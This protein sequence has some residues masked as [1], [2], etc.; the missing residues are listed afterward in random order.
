MEVDVVEFLNRFSADDLAEKGVLRGTTLVLRNN[1][2]LPL[3]NLMEQEKVTRLH[4]EDRG[5]HLTSGGDFANPLSAEAKAGP[6]AD[7][8]NPGN[9][10]NYQNTA[11]NPHYNGGSSAEAGDGAAGSEDDEIAANL[12][13]RFERD[14]QR[15]L[16]AKIEDLDPGLSVIDGGTERVVPA[17]KID[18]TAQDE[19]GHIVVIEL[20]AGTA[21]L[22]AIGQILSY[23]GTVSDDPTQP[24]RG[25]LI[26]NDFHPKLEFA[27]KAVP[28]VSLVAYSIEFAFQP[29]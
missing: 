26:A 5:W 14:L 8:E 7:L 29:R 13:F 20:K 17:G 4:A 1:S 23:M 12:K 2:V 27:V 24:V 3:L 10:F 18:I 22:R 19:T 25:I 15:N 9:V 11:I 28:N 6:V 21:D 16:R